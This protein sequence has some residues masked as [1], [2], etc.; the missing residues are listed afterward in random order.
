MHE[1]Y[2]RPCSN[3]AGWTVEHPNAPSK[4]FKS[5]LTAEAAALALARRLAAAGAHVRTTMLLRDGSIAGV[6]L[7]D[8]ADAHGSKAG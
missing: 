7:T 2:V 1:I 3:P 4:V 6:I 5:E 8:P